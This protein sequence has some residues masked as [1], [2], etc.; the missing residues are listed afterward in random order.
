M[1]NVTG[2]PVEGEDLFDREKEVKHL[3]DRLETDH[4]LLLAPRRIGKTSLMLRLKSTAPQHG[5][6]ALVCSFAGCSDELDCVNTLIESVSE[7]GDEGES[8]LE[9]VKGEI[10]RVLPGLRSFT[11][12]KFGIELAKGDDRSHW[13]EVAEILIEKLNDQDDG[14]WLLGVDE[15]PVF[16]NSLLKK[17]DGLER[18][19]QFL[20]WFRVVRQSQR[21]N[22]R[23][24]LAGSIGLDTV[25]AR[26]GLGDT[27][28]DLYIYHLD[29]FTNDTADRFLE[30]LGKDYDVQFDRPT[31]QHIIG[32]LGW[33]VP[34]YLQHIF[35]KIH[36][37][38]SDNG[39]MPSAAM[40]D[41]VFEVMLNPAHKAL[42]DYWRQRLTEELGAPDDSYAI[43]L[44][45]HICQDLN[46]VTRATLGQVLSERVTEQAV[47]DERLRYLLDVLE[48]DGYLV[49]REGR[50][51]FRLELL[52]R[53]WQ[54]RVAS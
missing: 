43:H 3:W 40:V 48:T 13:R 20:N 16:L 4:I 44:L 45:N 49:L 8:L 37:H 7:L 9:R 22:V 21:R 17:R 36:E 30:A 42:F 33:P 2:S 34:F 35:A 14:R 15:V 38:L 6:R 31:R 12:G 54:M 41:E 18:G 23:W 19:R 29:A 24:L 53:Y 52:R 26:L 46:G 51:S 28:N 10:Q 1:R 39:G 50:Y 27:I 25:S 11:L 5:Y 32:A 47:R